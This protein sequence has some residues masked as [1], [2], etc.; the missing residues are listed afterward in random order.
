MNEKYNKAGYSVSEVI[1]MLRKGE[2]KNNLS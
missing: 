2:A 1:E